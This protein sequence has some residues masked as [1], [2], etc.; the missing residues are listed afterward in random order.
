MA[1]G[2]D[3]D[4]TTWRD[5]RAAALSLGVTDAEFDRAAGA[6]LGA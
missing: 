4:D 2:I 3:V 6:N 5:I 1:E